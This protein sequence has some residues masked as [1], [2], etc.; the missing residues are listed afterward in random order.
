MYARESS[1]WHYKLYADILGV[2]WT[3]ASNDTGWSKGHF[4]VLSVSVSSEARFFVGF[5]DDDV[6]VFRASRSPDA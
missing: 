2:F 1:F 6:G 5:Y 4:S 3:D